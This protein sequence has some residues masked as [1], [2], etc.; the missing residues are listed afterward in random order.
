M[1]LAPTTHR[2]YVH[3]A[4]ARFE[5]KGQSREFEKILN[6]QDKRIQFTLE[7]ENGEKCLNFLDI[8]K[9]NKNGRY[10]FNVHRKP[11]ITNVQT[12]PHSCIPLHTVTRIFK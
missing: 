10:E 3:D 8:K 6:K 12:K 9:K 4:H 5:C 1:N 2:P 7:D 11:V